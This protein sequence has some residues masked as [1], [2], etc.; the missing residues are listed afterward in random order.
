MH[1]LVNHSKWDLHGVF[2]RKL[3]RENLFEE[4]LQEREEI[5][6]RRHLSVEFFQVLQQ[7]VRTLDELP[8]DAG[9]SSRSSNTAIDATGL[10][11]VQGLTPSIYAMTNGDLSGRGYQSPSSSYMGSPRNTNSRKSS[12]SGEQ[13]SPLNSNM[14][15]NGVGQLSNLGA[16]YP[17]INP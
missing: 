17:T 12:H 4:M 1:F 7:A 16:G 14:V 5:A 10:P 8:L 11:R 13:P 2:I 15:A 6:V 3:Y 9:A